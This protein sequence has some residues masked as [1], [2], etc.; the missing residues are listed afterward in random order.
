MNTQLVVSEIIS[1]RYSCRTYREENLGAETQETLAPMLAGEHRGPL[2]TAARFKLIAATAG[3]RDALKDL[4]T[5]G[6]IRGARGYIVGAVKD[7]GYGLEDYGYLMEEH[8]LSATRLGLGTCWLGGSFTKSTFASA[9][10]A[11]E[12]EV[13]PAVTA[14]GYP[15]ARRRLFDAAVRWGAGSD[16]RKPSTDLFFQGDFQTSLHADP[17]SDR[18]L[19]MVRLAPSAS[20]RQPWRIVA[21]ENRKTFHFYLQRTK[22]YYQRN[23]VLFNMADLQRVDMGIAMCHFELTCREMGLAGRWRIQDPCITRLPDRTEYLVTWA[24]N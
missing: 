2:G 5:Y 1:R 20:N 19:E 18:P 10:S 23:R 6:F 7:S 8:I 11:G 21:D 9:V 15:A 16:N 12:Q 3:H 17:A 4:G 22:R 14:L 24:G 13:V